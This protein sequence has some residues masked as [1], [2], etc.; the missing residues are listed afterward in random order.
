V[1]E[2]ARHL[3]PNLGRRMLAARFLDRGVFLRELLPQELQL[4]IEHLTREEAIK[5]A[6]YPTF[7]GTGPSAIVYALPEFIWDIS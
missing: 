4:E 5:V 2:G 1:V 6:R 7:S 3:K